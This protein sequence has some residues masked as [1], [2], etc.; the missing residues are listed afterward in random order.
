MAKGD[1]ES[2]VAMDQSA[3][4]SDNSREV[5]KPMTDEERLALA[6]KLDDELDEFINGLEK[7]RYTD[8]WYTE[9]IKQKCNND[10]LNATLYQNRSTAQ[11]YLQNFRSSLLDSERALKFA[12]DYYKA[13]FR[14]AKAA[15]QCMKYSQCIE[16]C[17]KI[18]TVKPQDKDTADLLAKAKQKLLIQERDDRRKKRLHTIQSQQRDIILKTVKERGIRVYEWKQNNEELDSELEFSLLETKTATASPEEMVHLEDGVLHW[19]VLLI[20][21]EYKITDYIKACADTHTLLSEVEQVFPAPWDDEGKYNLGNINVYYEG[22]NMKLVSVDPKRLL[23]EL[24]VDRF[25]HVKGGMASF[26]ILARGS[27]AEKRFLKDYE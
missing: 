16:Y 5:K 21:P 12:P 20:Y 7:K 23:S 26:I 18:L 15:F 2:S 9:G 6:K 11:F 17:Q 24:M 8:G 25:F 14:A 19:P 1:K 4:S 27:E 10:D 22:Y 13:Q 3:G